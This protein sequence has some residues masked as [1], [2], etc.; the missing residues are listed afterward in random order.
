MKIERGVAAAFPFAATG[1]GRP[2]VILAGLW[3]TTGVDSDT[4]VRG[5]LTPLRRLSSRRFVVFNRRAQLGSD[6]TLAELAAEQARAIQSM[7][8]LPVDVVGNSTGGSIAQLL[9]AD[10]PEIVRRLVLVSTACRLTEAGRELDAR[11][12]VQ[13]RAGRHRTGLGLAAT[14]LAPPGLRTLGRGVAWAAARRMVPDATAAADLAATL[15]AENAFDLA[16]C[17]RPIRATTLIIAGGKD[18]FYNPELLTDTAALIPNSQLQVFPRRGH[19]TVT[20]DRRAQAMIA[21]FLA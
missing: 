1:E 5:A 19:I 11:V 2:V 8:D 17:G 6:I 7:F 14:S 15:E 12:A 13:L 21:G 20:S 10:H 3:P 16:N 9:A 4:L 18:R